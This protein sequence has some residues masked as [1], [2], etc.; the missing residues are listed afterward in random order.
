[1]TQMTKK[2]SK[3]SNSLISVEHNFISYY[4][5]LH[6]NDKWEFNIHK[7]IVMMM[8]MLL[9]MEMVAKA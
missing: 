3:Q 1:M 9:M 7:F 5:L 2:T 8:Y 4:G 6:F